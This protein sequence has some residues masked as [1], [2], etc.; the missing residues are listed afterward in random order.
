[1]ARPAR[2]KQ[3]R[4]ARSLRQLS[5]FH[6][7]INADTVFGTHTWAKQAFSKAEMSGSNIAGQPAHSA[8]ACAV[9]DIRV[10]G[11]RK[12]CFGKGRISGNFLEAMSLEHR[13]GLQQEVL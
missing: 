5:R 4:S 8:S 10:A 12:Q 7:A 9:A 3:T 1:M 13:P 11:A 2:P 6:R